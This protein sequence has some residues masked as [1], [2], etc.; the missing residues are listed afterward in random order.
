[1]PAITIATYIIYHAIAVISISK[2][3]YLRV[4]MHAELLFFLVY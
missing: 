1:M 3:F 2:P 4:A